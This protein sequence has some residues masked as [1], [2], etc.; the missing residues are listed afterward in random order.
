MK[1]L[2]CAQ[3][4]KVFS[5][6]RN[7]KRHIKYWCQSFSAPEILLGSNLD[8]EKFECD[9]CGQTFSEIRS[10]RRHIDQKRCSNIKYTNKDKSFS[11]VGGSDGGNSYVDTV[12]SLG[13]YENTRVQWSG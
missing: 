10:L 1:K 11:E 2:S 3:T 13:P 5:L 7:L 8:M 12:S 4:G 6:E 9:I